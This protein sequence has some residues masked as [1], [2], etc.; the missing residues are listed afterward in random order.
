[1]AYSLELMAY[2]GTWATLSVTLS[3]SLSHAVSQSLSVSSQRID[4]VM[5][6]T[7]NLEDG[8]TEMND[9][10]TVGDC[11]PLHAASVTAL[12]RELANVHAIFSH[13]LQLDVQS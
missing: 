11:V 13:K 5:E 8:A 12:G 2:S 6:K 9:A 10:M 4:N 3:L 1:M 7:T